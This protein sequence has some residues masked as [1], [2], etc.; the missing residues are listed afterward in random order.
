M[1]LSW[2]ATKM[3][4]CVFLLQFAT[5]INAMV[6][7]GTLGVFGQVEWMANFGVS[8][9]HCLQDVNTHYVDYIYTWLRFD[10]CCR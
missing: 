2:K 7:C 3:M 1:S 6:L 5:A 8:F 10:H 9:L 4:M